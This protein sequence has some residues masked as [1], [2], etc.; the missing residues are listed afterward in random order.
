MAVLMNVTEIESA[1]VFIESTYPSLC[2]RVALP[3]KTFENRTCHALVLGQKTFLPRPATLIIGG[4]HAREWGGPDIVVNFAIDLLKA[5]TASK[6]LTYLQ[7]SFSAAEIKLIVEKSTVVVFPC[8]NPDGVNFSQNDTGLWRKNRNPASSGGVPGNIGVDINRNYDFV[9]D[10]KKHFH[11]G[12]WAASLASDRPEVETFHGTSPFSEPETR[13]V[14][15]LM[16]QHPATRLFLDLH[17]FTGDV[18]YNWGDDESQTSEPDKNFLNPAYDGKRGLPGDV[19]GEYIDAQDLQ[20]ISGIA[21]FVSDAMKAVRGRPYSASPAVGLYP[22]AGA[23]DDYAFSRHLADANLGKVFGFTLEFNFA[24]DAT[25]P[26]SPFHVTADPAVLDKTMQDVIPGLIALCLKGSEFKLPL[27][28]RDYVDLRHIVY[29]NPATGEI[30]YIDS[31]GKIVK[32][33]PPPP[34]YRE[35]ISVEIWKL[36]NAFEA[37]RDVPGRGG[38]IARKGLMDAVA[39]IAKSKAGRKS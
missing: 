10:Y 27:I 8:V 36:L 29:V 11:S 26:Q 4:V 28:D 12:A 22:T 17:S 39:R 5:Y 33:P 30:W 14:K 37:I 20:Q 16:D 9:W 7:K 34:P 21:Q 15:W 13:N 18:L 32:K 25:S 2:T 35:A 1:L 24:S 6:G 19:Y 38:D 31:H 23:S 3:E